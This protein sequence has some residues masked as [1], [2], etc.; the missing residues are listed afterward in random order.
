MYCDS[1]HAGCP[2]TRFSVSGYCTFIVGGCV[3]WR[4]RK[5]PTVPTSTTEVKYRAAY[6]ASQEVIWLH[7]LLSDMNYKVKL[8]I[9]LY[10]DN[11]GALALTNNLLYQS[12]SKHFDILYHWIQE[13]VNNNSISPTYITTNLRGADFLTKA[14]D[15]L[16]EHNFCARELGLTPPTQRGGS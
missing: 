10:C 12:R 3:S 13:R 16:P 6:K 5:Q 11:Q 15:H 2:Y 9:T 7:Q 8:P 4:A 1:D 14:V